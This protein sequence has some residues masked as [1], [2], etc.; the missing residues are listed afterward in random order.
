MLPLFFNGVDTIAF[1]SYRI[2]MEDHLF[3]LF[4]DNTSLM[5]HCPV[6]NLRYDPLEARVV[7]E[8]GASHLVHVSCRFCRSA[9]I[10]I[11]VA[12]TAG[13]NSIGLVTDMTA[14][15]VGR[16]GGN[17]PLTSDDVL[18]A[19]QFLHKERVLSDHLD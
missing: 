4:N 15:D 19:Y 9:I 16:F 10:A 8:N 6:C 7:R 12:N 14:D 2:V 11:I 13:I 3:N 5:T 1:F 17:Q 18:E